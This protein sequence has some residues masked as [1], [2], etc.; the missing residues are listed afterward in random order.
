M[1]AGLKCDIAAV[2][3]EF[4]TDSRSEVAGMRATLYRSK[5]GS[6]V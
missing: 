2:T 1:C 5:P 6:P 3:K 4:L